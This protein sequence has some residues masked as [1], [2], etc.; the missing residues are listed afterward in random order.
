M[1]N[2]FLI[3][4]SLLFLSSTTSQAQTRLGKSV[5]VPNFVLTDAIGEKVNL[6]VLLKNN[7]RVLICFFRPVWC[8]ICNKR[9][10]E[11]IERY[12]E[13]KA[14][15]IEVVAVYPTQADIMAQYV[16]DANIPFPVIADPQEALYEVYSIERSFKKMK[17]TMKRPDFQKE[18]DEGT[19]LY[20]GKLYGNYSEE[21]S[22]I[23]NADFLLTGRRQVEIAYYGDYVGDHYDLDKL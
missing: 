18:V 6:Q 20:G 17:E 8:A 5:K 15:G 10:H 21:G 9:T 16:K 3:L 22:P 4:V 23:I 11:L 13:L 1:K 14:K 19:A 2:T 12:D 7:E